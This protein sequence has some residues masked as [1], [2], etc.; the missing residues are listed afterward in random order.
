MAAD[1]ASEN[2]IGLRIMMPEEPRDNSKIRLSGAGDCSRKLAYV[3][4]DAP[5]EPD[6]LRTKMTFAIGHALHA[7]VQSWLQ[8][9]GWL[10]P[11]FTE[12]TLIDEKRRLRGTVDGITERLGADGYPNPEGGRRIIEIKTI[13]NQPW[14]SPAG[15]VYD[16]A[17]NRL[18]KPKDRHIDQATAYAMLWNDQHPED[19][20]DKLTFIYIAKDGGDNEMP[21]KVFTQKPTAKRWARLEEKFARI[22]ALMDAGELP[23]PD[24]NLLNPFAPCSYCP[25][26]GLC[27]ETEEFYGG[28]D[29]FTEEDGANGPDWTGA[30]DLPVFPE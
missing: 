7:M 13:T 21:I 23:P 27:L 10:K 2:R 22:W 3:L 15:K 14:T 18:D 6:A 16:G 28:G 29:E 17:F 26:K 9:I 8:D 4:M 5:K 1:P 19:P 30:D 25:Y 20:I 11:E 24:Y 12:F